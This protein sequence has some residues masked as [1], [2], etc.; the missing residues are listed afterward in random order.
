MPM[1]FVRVKVNARGFGG[2]ADLLLETLER[3]GVNTDEVTYEGVT[4]LLLGAE[5]E[6]WTRIH[7]VVPNDVRVPEYVPWHENMTETNMS[8]AVQTAAR[9]TLRDVH[10]RLRPRLQDTPYRY[11]PRALQESDSDREAFQILRE[12]D[13]EPDERL[14]VASRCILAQDQAL[15]RAD[16]SVDILR[17]GWDE[18]VAKVEDFERQQHALQTEMAATNSRNELEIA[19]LTARNVS[20][21]DTVRSEEEVI[22]HKD[23]LLEEKNEHVDSMSD[24]VMEQSEK[25]QRHQRHEKWNVDNLVYLGAKTYY[26]QDRVA[27]IATAWKRSDRKRVTEIT[28][29][30]EGQPIV[31]RKKPRTESYI[32]PTSQCRVS[33]ALPAM[34][35]PSAEMLKASEKLVELLEDEE[36]L[37]KLE[38]RVHDPETGPSQTEVLDYS[39]ESNVED[40]T[41]H[42]DEPQ[43]VAGGWFDDDDISP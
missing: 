36:I 40:H 35:L 7:T 20:L 5:D 41:T 33:T 18:S 14:R 21:E 42:V 23:S 8:D 10:M 19:T 30:G 3:A 1:E 32:L 31:L 28:E 9:R 24:R 29:A 22:K 39:P 43:Y 15:C 38:Q 37:Y 6:G 11:L 27:R 13:Y 16:K 17:D 4:Q 25:I 2:F 26:N 34:L 12:F